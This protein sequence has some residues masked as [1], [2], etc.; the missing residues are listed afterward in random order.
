MVTI[1]E[2]LYATQQQN[3]V[4][5]HDFRYH[6][7]LQRGSGVD[8][9]VPDGWQYEDKGPNGSIG[10]NADTDQCVIEK[11]ENDQPMLF[12][13]VISEFPRWQQ[14]LLGQTISANFEINSTHGDVKLFLTDGINSSVMVVNGSRDFN[15]ALQLNV[16][17]D[18]KHVT[19]GIET[20][21]P[22]LKL[23]LS[24]IYA[25]LGQ[26]ALASL[27]C[28]VVGI[29]GEQKQY[30]A[31]EN[32]P[33]EELSLCHSSTELSQQYTRLNT[34]LNKR[35]G[36][37]KN[38]YS[39]LPDIRGYFGRAW[40]NG[41]ATDPDAKSRKAWGDSKV[42]GD[43]VGTMQEDAFKKHSHDLRFT[44]SKLR[45]GAQGAATLVATDQLSKTVN[46]STSEET[47]SKN[48]S[49]LYTIKWA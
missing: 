7:N 11:S 37:G 27:P 22:F 34:V 49:K 17:K 38:G 44:I 19:L 12:Q 4:Y 30:I 32:P 31:T 5:N 14:A 41:S 45:A 25:N 8:Y 28:K 24:R 10:F 47:R 21:V 2:Q 48:I 26:V 23:L 33:A 39:L 1:E 46:A 3:L 6:S 36:E 18:A 16:S 40:D 43:H 13:Q 20:S 29:I 15:V 35:F 42:T 9:G